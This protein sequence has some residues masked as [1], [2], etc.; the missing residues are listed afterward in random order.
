VRLQTLAPAKVNL[1]L[2]V[3][4][5]RP[6]GFHDIDSLM[7][8]LD[9][10]DEVDVRIGARAGPV[11]CRVPR[12]PELDGPQNLAARAAEAFRRRFGID[13]AIAIR[14]VKRTPITAGLGGGSSDAAAV[15]RCLAR[16]FKVRD[17][18]ALE[19]IALG[20]GSD[21]PFFL[22]PGPAWA[23]GRGERLVPATVPALDLVLAYP[24]DAGLA[25]RAGD[26]YRWVDAARPDPTRVQIPRW[27]RRF[28]PRAAANDLEGPCLDRFPQLAAL[29]GR[30]AGLGA[31]VAMMSG[32][33]PT[34]FGIFGSRRAARNVAD[35]MAREGGSEIR[36][37]AVR[38]TQR[39][40]RVAPWRSPKSASSR[41]T[42]RS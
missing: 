15:I 28:S 17:G 34:V 30:L 3:G 37:F 11:T 12:H 42:R 16:A 41:S 14:I 8:P 5:L 31:A 32:S 7:V 24:T 10:G 27:I 39:H 33:G 6:D 19:E 13:R 9:F 25:I 36:V 40:P 2:R 4:P 18:A 21:V 35:V 20:V 38:T 29:R 1:V 26:A 23:A 22:G